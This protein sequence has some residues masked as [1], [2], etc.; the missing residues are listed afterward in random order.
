LAQIR[1]AVPGIFHT[2]TKTQ[3]D[4]ANN[5][6]FRSSLRAI[7]IRSDDL[8][9]VSWSPLKFE[10][11]PTLPVNLHDGR[12]ND[13]A[14]CR[15][16][17]SAPPEFDAATF[18]RVVSDTTLVVVLYPASPE[19]GDITHYYVVVVPDE[20]TH[21]RRPDDFKI[22]E[23]FASFLYRYTSSRTPIRYNNVRVPYAY[24]S[25]TRS[26]APF[27]QASVATPS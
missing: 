3:T 12:C 1:S 21:G 9:M 8:R 20:L 14:C 5:T 19:N 25:D 15:C 23:V 24:V 17:Y 4:G 13:D 27:A 16:V 10:R 2:Q 6:T 26:R 22:D 18:Y 11:A 7:K